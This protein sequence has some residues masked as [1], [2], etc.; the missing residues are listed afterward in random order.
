MT[1]KSLVKDDTTQAE[2][3]LRRL[4][5]WLTNSGYRPERH[6]M[7]GGGRPTHT[8]RASPSPIE[9]KEAPRHRAK[10]HDAIRSSRNLSL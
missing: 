9:P 2:V 7:R 10:V 6:Y 8:K 1:W 4:W 5:A 3:A